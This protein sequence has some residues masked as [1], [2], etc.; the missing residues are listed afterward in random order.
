MEVIRRYVCRKGEGK[1]FG[2]V[3]VFVFLGVWASPPIALPSLPISP[4]LFPLSGFCRDFVARTLGRSLPPLRQTNFMN[5]LACI[6]F[7][8][9]NVCNVTQKLFYF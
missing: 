5:H 9:I 8:I 7:R 2:A 6:C 4:I 3:G 1:G